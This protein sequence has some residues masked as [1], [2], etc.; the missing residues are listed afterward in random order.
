MPPPLT[1]W[2]I[3][4]EER[5]RAPFERLIGTTSEFHLERAFERYEEAAAFF[6]VAPPPD[7]VVLDLKLPGLSGSAAVRDL[8]RR[9]PRIPVVILTT[10]DH[11]D[12]V[13]DVLRAGASGYVVKGTEPDRILTALREAHAGGSY[14]SPSVARH[15]LS[16]F[17]AAPH[18]AEPL[19]SRECDVLREL[20]GGRSKAQIAAALYLSPHTIDS[21]LRTIYRKLH[22][23]TAAEATA[24][25]VRYGLV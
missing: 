9:H 1:L 17:T 22:V 2:L 25:A 21:H 5:F 19:S 10:S 4:D 12:V 3:E 8:Q 7:L 15:V 11:P 24:K 23:N 18:L 13:F 6:E 16:H 14:F 20:A